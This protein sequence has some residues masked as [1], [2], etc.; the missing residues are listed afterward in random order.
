M[1]ES[2]VGRAA[3]AAAGV[4][5]RDQI[6][7]LAF[8]RALDVQQPFLDPA[9]IERGRGA[10]I[11][12]SFQ[13]FQQIG[14]ALFEM[15]KRRGVVVADRHAVEAFG[16]RA[17][18]AFD[19]FGRLGGRSAF[20]A[21]QRRGQRGQ[22]LLENGK[23]IALAVG[24]GELVDLGRQRMHVFGKPRQ[25]VV[26]GDI[27]DDRA[28]RRD[29]VF[30]LANGRR[31]VVGAQDQVELG[32][33]AADRVVVTGELLGRRQLAQRAMDFGERALD[34]QQ[35]LAVGAALAA[36]VDAAGQRAD[37]VLDRIDGVARHRFGD[38]LADFGEFAAERRDRRLDV[39]GGTQRFELARD[40]EQMTF[41]R[42][43]VRTGD[44]GGR[45]RRRVARRHLL[46]RTVEFVLPRG[47]L[48]NRSVER[49]RAQRRRGT[50]DL[51][52]GAIDHRG[53]CF[54]ARRRNWRRSPAGSAGARDLRQPGVE[55][56]NGVVELAGHRRLGR[57]GFAARR[58]AARGGLR[59]LLDLP[60]DGIQPLVDVGDVAAFPGG[61]RWALIAGIMGS[62]TDGFADGGIEPLTERH[63]G[64]ARGRFG[65]FANRGIDAVNTP[66]YARIHAQVR[67]RLRR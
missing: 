59:N 42:G 43:K 26:G 41:E 9:E 40:V 3:A 47:D 8:E 2:I 37:F 65:P 30:E 44:G 64:A 36:V 60:G 58:F 7:V 66:R 13:P 56:G 63:A 28:Q 32:A 48:G 49:D 62:G 55:A 24:A 16:Q 4:G 21:F 25:R 33:E 23:G 35:H 38:G 19:E 54:A 18:R 57:H 5:E 50:I 17:Q 10:S 53:L 51:G 45:R 29:R 46:R 22:P 11:G 39:I 34:A 67:F 31:V 12:R 61:H 20:A 6:G 1:P 14:H 15:G 52:R 27:G